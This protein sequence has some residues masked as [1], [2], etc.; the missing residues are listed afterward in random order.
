MY[1]KFT[2]FGFY[3][4]GSE[5]FHMF[6]CDFRVTAPY[7]GVITEDNSTHSVT[8]PNAS[9][10]GIEDEDELGA[11]SNTDFYFTRCSLL[12]LAA[13]GTAA[14][15]LQILSAYTVRIENCILHDTGNNIPLIKLA[16]EDRT[17]LDITI[18]GNLFHSTHKNAVEIDGTITQLRIIGNRFGTAADKYIA[19][20]S[21]GT[22]ELLK[23]DS[24]VGATSGATAQVGAI[25]LTSGTWAGG[26]AAGTLHINKQTGTFQSEN[27]N[28][29]NQINFDSG[30]TH[31][32]IAGDTI[33][34]ETS[35]ASATV[36]K[37]RKATG[38]W[39]DGDAAGTFYLGTVTGGPFQNDETVKDNGNLNCATID[40]TITN[41]T[42]NIATIASDS[43]P[44]ANII[45][46]ANS[47]II[48]S[49]IEA[50]SIDFSASNVDVEGASLIK[51]IEGGRSD[52]GY[53]SIAREAKGTIIRP[54][55]ASVTL[56]G[57]AGTEVACQEILTGTNSVVRNWG[58]D[59]YKWAGTEALTGTTDET[60]IKTL[61]LLAN[62]FTANLNQSIRISGGGTITSAND[63]KTI[64]LKFGSN[65]QTIVDA[66]NLADGTEW[67]FDFVITQ[68]ASGQQR[69]YG[70]CLTSDGNIRYLKGAISPTED[71]T[72]DISV[73][74]VGTLANASD[75]ITLRNFTIT[76]L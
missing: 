17:L 36:I 46:T 57:T 42:S 25:I 50:E 53:L 22:H 8:I 14:A 70:Q 19:F 29:A 67:V 62:T 35:G 43:S 26:D 13:D 33:T 37:V 44:L 11:E 54:D 5:E 55:D 6:D 59:A 1:G 52:N 31:Q 66:V 65:S 61:T 24:I 7:V 2:D 75:T 30:G 32:I 64:K 12:N 4:Y 15:V 56:S 71:E 34:G 23:T 27:L 73:S 72:S 51:I 58:Q 10:L 9:G 45:A 49:H 28:E 69:G 18:S 3:N 63:A 41:G 21:G 48:D 47:R 16:Q 20:T 68:V 38:K 74:I 60:T 40:G 76:T 39:S